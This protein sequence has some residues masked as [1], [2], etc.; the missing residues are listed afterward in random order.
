MAGSKNLEK[1][2]SIDTSKDYPNARVKFD[3]YQR[4][5]IEVCCA[6]QLVKALNPDTA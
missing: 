4:S 2:F 1:Y 5:F 6:V 3:Y